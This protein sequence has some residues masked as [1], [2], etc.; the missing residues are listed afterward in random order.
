MVSERPISIH[1][2]FSS[3]PP[4]LGELQPLTPS[5]DQTLGWEETQGKTAPTD[6]ACKVSQI[7]KRNIQEIMS[8]KPF[9]QLTGDSPPEC[10]FVT[11]SDV[12]L[13][14]LIG[15]GAF[16]SIYQVGSLQRHKVK[17]YQDESESS[18]EKKL[19][20]DGDYVVKV[21]KKEVME[22][23]HADFAVCAADI[24]KEAVLM[25]AIDHP[26]ILKARAMCSAGATS[27]E[28][29]QR[30]DSFFV[31]MDQLDDTLDHRIKSWSHDESKLKR[32]TFNPGQRQD[33]K[34]Q[35][36]EN[37]LFRVGIAAQIADAIAYLHRYHI[38]HRDIK[39]TNIG[40][41]AKGTVK[42]FDM[43]NC[44]LI[45][46]ATHPDECFHLTKNVGTL[47]Y[48]APEVAL[49]EPYNAKA[50]VYSFALV[51]YAMVALEK[52]FRKLRS[53][54]HR[55]VVFK[56]G[57]RP[58]VHSSWP[59]MIQGLLPKMWSKD[60]LVRPTMAV[61]HRSLSDVQNLPGSR[62]PER[63]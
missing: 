35:R 30:H 57:L 13:G 38:L 56:Q 40:F 54:Q 5:G 37:L 36:N 7:A 42:I 10:S 41:D 16:N 8:S 23:S 26:N 62:Q 58:K 11:H 25:A 63:S 1:D 60:W 28:A 33:R 50:D 20:E 31:V 6:V 32:F 21:L 3:T 51:L 52:P 19:Q 27:F 46:E 43:D 59:E 4:A 39:I 55:N 18:E 45:P 29:T 12:E 53:S 34:R 14:S 44:R 47:R 49:G 15:Q 48:I 61:V 17:S 24:V 9:Q 22:K 2:V